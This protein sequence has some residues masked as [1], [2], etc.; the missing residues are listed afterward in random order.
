LWWQREVVVLVLELEEAVSVAELEEAGV[1]VVGGEGS[2]SGRFRESTK[3]AN[4]MEVK[5]F[6][7][8]VYTGG[9][10]YIVLKKYQQQF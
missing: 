8:R 2:S 6:G 5:R 1:A 3:R 10:I 7:G 4:D 9:E